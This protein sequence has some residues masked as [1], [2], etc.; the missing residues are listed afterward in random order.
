MPFQGT[1]DARDAVLEEGGGGGFAI[2]GYEYQ[3]D[4]SVWLA[5]DLILVSR[6]AQDLLLEPASQEDLEAELCDPEPGRLVNHVPMSGY[7]LIVQAK[8]REGNAWTPKTLKSLL[9]YGSDHRI[10]AS[11]RLE[12]PQCR[13]LLVTSAGVNS[14]AQKLNRRRPGMWPGQGA[15][16]RIIADSLGHDIS[17]RFSVIANQDDERLRVDI[18][19]LLRESCRVPN[20]RLDKCRNQLRE[21]ARAR[22]AGVGGG[23]WKR[24]ELEKIIRD[25]DGYLSSSAEL[26]HYV[27]PN[28]WDEL[29]AQID[30]KSAAIIIG[31]SGT[32]KTLA[33]QMLYDELRKEIHGLTRVLIRQGPSQLRDDTTPPPVLYDIEDPWGRF[34]FDPNSRPWNDQI[35]RFLADA[36]PDRMIIATSRMDVAMES[37]ALSAVGNWVVRL[38]AENY[39]SDQR[40]RL[41]KSRVESLPHELQAIA[42]E[43]QGEVLQDL[44]TPLEIQKFFDAMRPQNIQDGRHDFQIVRESIRRAHQESIEQTVIEQIETRG[45][46]Q[47]ATIL[48]ALMESGN[49]VTRSILR[50]LEDSFYDMETKLDADV[51]SLVDFFVAARNIRQSDDGVLSYYHPRVEAGIDRA[52][53]GH[54][55][56]VRQTLRSLIDFLVSAENAE[57]RW[58][59]EAAVRILARGNGPFEIRLSQN[60]SATVDAWLE[61]RLAQGG[62]AF[63]DNL[64]LA[65]QAGSSSC[66]GAELARFLLH[67]EVDEITEV[68]AW[69][70]PERVSDWYQ[71]RLKCASTRPLL[72]I[73][74]RTVLTQ[75]H[76][77]YPEAFAQYLARLSI[78]LEVAFLDA[79][80]TIVG[81]S[82]VDSDEAIAYGALQDFEGYESIVDMAVGVL[83]LTEDDLRSHAETRMDVINCVYEDEYAED[84]ETNLRGHTA[85]RLLDAYIETARK[86]KLHTC[87]STHRHIEWI[88]PLW[89]KKIAESAK[90][91]N[92]DEVEFA[93]AFEAGFGTVDEE[94]LWLTLSGCWNSRYRSAL[95]ARLR[96]GSPLPAIEHSAVACLLKN[97]SSA[98]FAVVADLLKHGAVERLVQISRVV[99]YLCRN[100]TSDGE[101]H[102]SVAASAVGQLPIPFDEICAAEVAAANGQVP[103]LS[104]A[105]WKLLQD[106]DDPGSM[107]RSLRLHLARSLGFSIEQDVRWA[108][109]ASDDPHLAVMAVELAIQRGM[110][111][112]VEGALAHRFAHVVARALTSVAS[113]L[114]VPLPEYLLAFSSHRAS[115]VRLALA[116]VL[117]ARMHPAYKQTLAQLAGDTWS[118]QSCGDEHPIARVAIAG[119]ASLVE[120]GMLSDHEEIKLLLGNGLRSSDE[121]V[122]NTTCL[123]LARSSFNMQHHLLELAVTLRKGELQSAAISALLDSHQLLDQQLIDG[124]TVEQMSISHEKVASVLAV[125]LGIRGTPSVVLAMAKELAL[126]SHRSIFLL[127]VARMLRVRSPRTAQDILQMVTADQRLIEWTLTCYSEPVDEKLFVDL[128]NPAAR[129]QVLKYFGFQAVPHKSEVESL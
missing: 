24:Q 1:H 56:K 68:N 23:R 101:D 85:R 18:D 91:D 102:Q 6:Q 39:G 8:R 2:A 74:I 40:R 73:F 29:R 13:Y 79:A 114:E 108:L 62:K 70:A 57:T 63:E 43:F 107:I 17:G 123:L 9:E 124:I 5:L 78:G 26:E 116:T 82:F 128:G 98:A 67:C 46:V 119:L 4:V 22:I 72:E 97:E 127:L 30:S 99:A 117:T 77:H 45:D 94:F 19:R 25:H 81:D 15:L 16:P 118:R 51:S 59:T 71:T 84:V 113:R 111:R 36:R 48:W 126:D 33:T 66:N 27:H 112:E 89:L 115:P 52:I 76:F 37:G 3:I 55:Q 87:M 122:L 47:A 60:A 110:F 104:A 50:A 20:A 129:K 64:V 7:T 41:Y 75:D 106:I 53:K 12:N 54:R 14:E 32:G 90:A 92:V 65:S 35:A 44:S 34:D 42:W 11:K 105:A 28:N 49:K 103:V 125:L 83:T 80:R 31:Q 96:D 38:E 93:A 58:G 10:S 61:A 95:L 21:A 100:S 121:E 86:N 120:F 109:K 69:R 88:R